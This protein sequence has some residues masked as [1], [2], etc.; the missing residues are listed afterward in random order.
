MLYVGFLAAILVFGWERPLKV[1]F[2]LNRPTAAASANGAP[3]WMN[4]EHRWDTAKSAAPAPLPTPSAG[5]P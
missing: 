3:S 2:G 5:K 4:N 1:Q